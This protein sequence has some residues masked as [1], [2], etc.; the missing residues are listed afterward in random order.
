MTLGK[1]RWLR[2]TFHT[3]DVKAVCP[4]IV[5]FCRKTVLG[6]ATISGNAADVHN[7]RLYSTSKCSNA[8]YCQACCGLPEVSPKFKAFMLCIHNAH[9]QAQCATQVTTWRANCW[10]AA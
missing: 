10:D 1:G 4:V 3:C 6:S 8:N 5:S 7:L 2:L 9:F